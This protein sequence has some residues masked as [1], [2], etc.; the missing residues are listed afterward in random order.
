MCKTYKEHLLTYRSCLFSDLW[1][2]LLIAIAAIVVFSLSVYH[3][4]CSL[5]LNFVQ[6]AELCICMLEIRAL[7]IGHY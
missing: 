1:F 6:R 2:E 3:R 7:E 4:G 5:H